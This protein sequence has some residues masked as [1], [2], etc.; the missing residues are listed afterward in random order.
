MYCPCLSENTKISLFRIPHTD[1]LY[2]RPDLMQPVAEAAGV[3]A[4]WGM[5][6]YVCCESDV[7][8]QADV[9][10]KEFILARATCEELLRL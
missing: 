1:W 6:K 4:G 7:S 9:L 5:Y 3:K 8:W 2:I 10:A